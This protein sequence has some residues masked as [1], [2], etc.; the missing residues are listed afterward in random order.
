MYASELDVSTHKLKSGLP[1]PKTA[2]CA[3]SEGFFLVAA[4]NYAVV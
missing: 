4:G 2:V 3:A 1:D